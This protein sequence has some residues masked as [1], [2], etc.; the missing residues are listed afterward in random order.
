MSDEILYEKLISENLE[1]NYQVKLVVSTFKDITY[2]SIRKYFLSFDE[3]FVPS[4][5]GISIPF[6]IASS[7]A[8]LDCMVD[9]CS[10]SE[11]I[12]AVKSHLANIQSE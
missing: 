6:E 2:F 3:G 8:I 4:K 1:K 11:G 7:Y 10:Q 9:L 5:E 12:E